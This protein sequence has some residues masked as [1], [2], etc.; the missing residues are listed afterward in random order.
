MNNKEFEIIQIPIENFNDTIIYYMDENLTF[1]T[2][3][4]FLENNLTLDSWIRYLS[5]EDFNSNMVYDL[6]E[7]WFTSNLQ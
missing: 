7:I 2:T 5:Q 6:K 1:A 3:L 4:R